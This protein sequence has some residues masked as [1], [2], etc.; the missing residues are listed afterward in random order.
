[1]KNYIY[2][3]IFMISLKLFSQSKKEVVHILFDK[4]NKEKCKINIEQTYRNKK[5]ISFVEKYRKEKKNNKIIFNICD[6]KFIFNY[7]KQKIDTCTIKSL[8]R[9]NVKSLDYLKSKYQKGRDFKH[10]IFEKINIIEKI[11]D[12]KIVKYYGVYWSGE[13]NIE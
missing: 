4:Y 7:E 10:H 5:G 2:I 11:S 3:L 6:E 1:M 8:N 12:K 9:F 13:W